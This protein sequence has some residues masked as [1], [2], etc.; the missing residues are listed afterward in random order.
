LINHV[1]IIVLKLKDTSALSDGQIGK[2]IAHMVSPWLVKVGL[3]RQTVSLT[4]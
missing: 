2:K 3:I 4:R 1:L